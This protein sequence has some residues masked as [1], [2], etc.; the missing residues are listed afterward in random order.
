MSETK[1]QNNESLRDERLEGVKASVE[2]FLNSAN[3]RR[4]NW[5]EEAAENFE[6]FFRWHASE[7]FKLEVKVEVYEQLQNAL[8]K[9]DAKTVSG[10]LSMTINQYQE[11]LLENKLYGMST[12]PMMNIAHVLGLE[13]KQELIYELNEMYNYIN[14]E[15][16]KA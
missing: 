5:E 16:E 14:N 6:H 13:A 9:Y 7:R 8:I 11:E 4:K 3:K 10:M 15:E 1:K 12:D 2:Y